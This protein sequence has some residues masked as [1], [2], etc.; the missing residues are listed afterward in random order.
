MELENPDGIKGWEFSKTI[1]VIETEGIKRALVKGQPYMRWSVGDEATERMAIAQIYELGLGTQEE[2]AEAFTVHVNSVSKYATA[3]RSE[4]SDGLRSGQRGP[5]QSWKVVPDVRGKILWIVLKDGIHEYAD[6]QRR[7]EEQWN[8]KVSIESIRQVLLDNGFVEESI[9][10]RLPEQGDLFSG[11][12]SRDLPLRFETDPTE[13]GRSVKQFEDQSDEEVSSLSFEDRRNKSHYA[14]AERRY[15][16]EL[17]R[18]LWSAYAGGLLFVPL[19]KRYH[20]LEKIKEVIDI[21]TYEGYSLQQLCLTFFY[22]DVFEFR[23]IEDFKTVYPEEYGPLTGKANSPSIYTLRRFLHKVR[24]LKK[25]EELIEEFSKEYLRSGLVQWGVLYIDSHFLP[26]YG[27][28]VITMGWHGVQDKALKGSYQ[29]LAVDEKFNPFLFLLRPSSEDLLEKIPELIEKA[30]KLGSEVGIDVED[31]TVVFDREG[32]SAE[33]F[34]KLN[35]MQPK[36]NFI[37]WAKYMNRW[38]DDYKDDQFNKSVMIQYEIQ[39]EEEIKYFETERM[40]NKY[41]KIR[42][43]IIESGHRKKRSAIFTN[44]NNTDGGRIIQLICRRW[45]HETLNKTQ[46]WDHKMDYHPGYVDEELE[47]QPL[48][49]NPKLK[50]LKKQKA[51]VV[52]KLNGLR[53]RFAQKTF[54]QAKDEASWKELKEKNNDLCMEMDSLQTQETLV[55]LEIDKFPKEVRFDEAHDGKQLMELDYEKKRFLD[56]IKVFT[57]MME[58]RMCSILSAYYDDPKDIYVIL[59]MIVRRGGE[60]KLE[61]GRLRVRLKGFK[62]PEVDFAARRLCEDLNQMQPRT[63]DKYRFPIRYEVG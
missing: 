60:I 4:G 25:G 12:G 10:W 35:E 34:R 30:R 42:T 36:V 14:P 31:L 16:D 44:D 49:E 18:G 23:S 41:G 2:L 55:D 40:M 52:S 47:E 59:S 21:P 3:F 61:E 5:K 11:G 22:F 20:F 32:Y 6:I 17:E 9:K 13:H 37:T 58:K 29:F 33:L 56:C 38:V 48:V 28:I 7:L 63:L 62:N 51:N 27:M 39:D 43:L 57:Y 53:I 50:E 15:L 26:Y 1:Q 24:K 19:I 8:K 46:K 54:A 45:G